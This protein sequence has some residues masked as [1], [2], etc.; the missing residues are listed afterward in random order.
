MIGVEDDGVGTAQLVTYDKHP[1][2]TPGYV[3]TGGYTPSA[4]N[5]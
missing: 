4:D 2:S 1:P 3:L 5:D